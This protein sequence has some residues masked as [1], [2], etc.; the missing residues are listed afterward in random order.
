MCVRFTVQRDVDIPVKAGQN[1]GFYWRNYGVISYIWLDRSDPTNANYVGAN[2]RPVKGD[3]LSLPW[4]EPEVSD[5]HSYRDYAIWVTYCR[6]KYTCTVIWVHY[7]CKCTC[8]VILVT[9]LWEC[10]CTVN[11]VTYFPF[12]NMHI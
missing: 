6:R 11:C 1:F 8:T 12:Q 10:T 2:D 7:C 5:G 3:V 9:Y 4:T